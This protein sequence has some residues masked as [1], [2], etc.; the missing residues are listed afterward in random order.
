VEGG[1]GGMMVIWFDGLTVMVFWVGGGGI[2][3]RGEEGGDAVLRRWDVRDGWMD[4]WMDGLGRGWEGGDMIF[5]IVS[6]WWE[7]Q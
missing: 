4:G 3:G 6:W 1:S 7:I 5:G 2:E